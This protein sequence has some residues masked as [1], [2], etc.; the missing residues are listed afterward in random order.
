VILMH[1]DRV[2]IGQLAYGL[3][4][5]AVALPLLLRGFAISGRSMRRCPTSGC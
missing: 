4:A 5:V 2:G 3:A 1:P